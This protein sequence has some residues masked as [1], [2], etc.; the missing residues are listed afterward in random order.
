MFKRA[1]GSLAFASGKVLSRPDSA[2]LIAE[3]ADICLRRLTALSAFVFG[4]QP[5]EV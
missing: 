5:N 3:L 2:D 1:D 4:Y